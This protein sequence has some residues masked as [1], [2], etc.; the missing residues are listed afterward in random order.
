MSPPLGAPKHHPAVVPQRG[1]D[2]VREREIRERRYLREG[3]VDWRATRITTGAAT[4]QSPN[5]SPDGSQLVFTGSPPDVGPQNVFTVEVDVTGPKQLTHFSDPVHAS[6]PAWSPDGTQ[7]VFT[8]VLID[9]PRIESAIWVMNDDGTNLTRLT[10][11]RNRRAR[12]H[13]DWQPL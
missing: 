8:R 5:W 13:P 7:I 1:D 3:S 6:D 10:P 9:N 2:R 12:A 4:D 11:S